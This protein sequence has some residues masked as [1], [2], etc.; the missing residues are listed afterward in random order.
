MAL[1]RC[2]QASNL[3]WPAWFYY[4]KGARL[5]WGVMKSWGLTRTR[6]ERTGEGGSKVKRGSGNVNTSGAEPPPP[7]DEVTAGERTWVLS[8]SVASQMTNEKYRSQ[9]LGPLG[10]SLSM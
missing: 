1:Q 8:G 5:E 4:R 6:Q 9:K 3:A 2:N 7:E 10:G